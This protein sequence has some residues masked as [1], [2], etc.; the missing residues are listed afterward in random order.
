MT[1]PGLPLPPP[2][3]ASALPAGTYDGAVVL[4][5]GGGTGLGKSIATEFGRLGAVGG[6]GEPG[7]GP[8]GRRR[9]LGRGGRWPGGRRRLRHP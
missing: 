8:P 7:R 5:T 1:P 6:G 9:G 2:V 3:G 4:V